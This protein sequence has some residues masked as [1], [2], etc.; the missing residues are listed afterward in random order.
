MVLD[1][2]KSE[3]YFSL[4]QSGFSGRLFETPI[5]KPKGV[6]GF[7]QGESKRRASFGHAFSVS[8]A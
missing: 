2:I 6:V 1:K 5:L 8:L 4:V 7:C 3:S